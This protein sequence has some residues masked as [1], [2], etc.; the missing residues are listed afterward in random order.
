MQHKRK[1]GLL[2]HPTSL[3]GSGG[4]GTLGKEAFAFVDFL[5]EGGQS[6][7]QVLPLTPTAYGNSPYSAYSAFAGNPLLIDLEAL[8]DEGDISPVDLRTKLPDDRVDY[9]RVAEYKYAVLKKAAISFFADGSDQRKAEFWQFCDTNYWLHDYALFMALKSLFAGKVWREWP[10]PIARR[11][12]EALQEYSQRLGSAIGEQKYMQWQFFKQWSALKTY[13]NT[14]GV[15]IFGDLP[16]FV[17]YDSTDV[18]ANRHLFHLDKEGRPTVVAGVPPDYFSESGQLWG[19]PL[20]HWESVAY[21]GY[22][23]W[24]ERFRSAFT[25]YDLLRIDHFRG[26]ESY[27]EVPAH[28]KTAINGRWVKGPGDNLFHAV[29]NALGELPIIAEDLG[30]ITPEVEA[31]RDRFDFPGMKILHFAFGSGPDNPYLP[32]NYLRNCV[33][34]TGTHDNDTTAGWFASLKPREKEEVLSYMGSCGDD[35]AWELIRTAMV[36]VA[37]HVIIPCQDLLSL[38]TD[39][40]MNMPGT[41]AGNWSWRLP[42]SAM[43]ERLAARLRDLTHLYGRGSAGRK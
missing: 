2:L 43:N 38:G 40:R 12:T 39:A 8:L 6:V 13:A 25:L 17:A 9:D 28:E 14:R 31:L 35:I 23:W 20:Y 36:S 22:T 41:S 21:H 27:W 19:N 10:E 37:D 29:R 4:I 3:P 18:W 26:F 15:E 42:A 5:Q 30:V 34:Y 16:I 1:S 32:H 24:I 11:E 33:V 7:W